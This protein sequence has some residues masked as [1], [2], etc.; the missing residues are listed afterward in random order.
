MKDKF[1]NNLKVGDKVY[2]Y[3]IL[4]NDKLDV[5]AISYYDK[6]PYIFALFG[7]FSLFKKG[8]SGP[9]TEASV[10]GEIKSIIRH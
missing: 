6:T 9:G 5:S 10:S 4:E 3:G 8:G 7:I 1:G 2:A